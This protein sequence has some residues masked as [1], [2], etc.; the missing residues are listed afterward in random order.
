MNTKELRVIGVPWHTA[1]QF[2]LAKIFKQY[3][4]ML[5]MW[6][7]WGSTS[8]NMPENMNIVLDFDPKDYDLAILHIDQ[9][10]IDPRISKGLLFKEFKK[11]T[12]GMKRVVINHMTPFH[13]QYENDQVISM[14]KE[15]VG[16][17]PMITN[18]EEAA[19]QWGWGTPIIHGLE[20][21]DWLDLPKEPRAV[22]CLSS[23]GMNKAYRRELLH[24]T[25]DI[26][27]ERGIEL[28]W[29][30]GNVKFNTVEEYKEY[31]GRSLVFVH[32]AWQSPM[33]RSRTEAML[34]GCCVVTTKHHD[35]SK[36]IEDGV[37]GFI[38]PDNPTVAADLIESL[39]TKRVREAVEI[40]QR[41][42]QMAIEKL[43]H[44]RWASDW[45]NFLSTKIFTES[46]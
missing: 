2:E 15:M 16:D 44:D 36:Y 10:C 25:M 27:K 33:P 46:I 28:I 35:I 13:D 8:R 18:S 21:N 24:A 23:A 39:I 29:I 38:V 11:L 14:I 19:V 30:M 37:N 17:I 12:E 22:A 4:L 41:G 31:L 34:S 43:N 9:Q 32:L 7:E 42:K 40:G 45:Q 26:L 20:A 6:R 3:D 5:N 1:H